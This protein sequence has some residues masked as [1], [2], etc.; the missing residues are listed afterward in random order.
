M[1]HL[2][3]VISTKTTKFT[4]EQY[5]K[6]K[7]A[8]MNKKAVI[9]C[10]ILF[11]VF[12][13]AQRSFR[14]I[15]DSTIPCSSQY[16]YIVE[17]MPRPKIAAEKME[18]LLELSVRFNEKEKSFRKDIFIQCVVNCRGKAGDFQILECPPEMINIGCQALQVLKEMFTEWEPG[19]QVGNAVDVLIRIKV[20]VEGGKFHLTGS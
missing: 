2:I 3:F 20:S 17:N 13:S 4:I 11:P 7:N 8:S 6:S 16:F 10:L 14:P 9:L 1:K 19:I 18:E 15:I 12:L 5:K